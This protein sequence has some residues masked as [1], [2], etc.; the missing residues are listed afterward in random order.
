MFPVKTIG[1]KPAKTKMPRPASVRIS[2]S[3]GTAPVVYTNVLMKAEN[4]FWST[5]PSPLASIFFEQAVD[6]VGCGGHPLW[7]KGIKKPFSDIL[8]FRSDLLELI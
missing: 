1:T 3:S 2:G 4:S 7:I 8:K 5:T 6:S